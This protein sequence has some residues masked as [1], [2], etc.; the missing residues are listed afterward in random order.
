MTA[1]AAAVP[2]DPEA[3]RAFERAGWERAAAGYQS[4][5]ATVTR[6][7]IDPLLEDARIG[8]GMNVLDIAC[9]TGLVAARVAEYGAHVVGL[10]FSKAMLALARARHPAIAFDEGDAEA[11]PYADDTFDAVVSNFGIHHV[12][13][14][15]LALREACRVLRG[16]GRVAFTVWA[17]PAETIAWKLLFD[18]LARHGD[19]AAANA[20]V[21]GG[22]LGSPG[23][24]IDALRQAGF[25]A[26]QPRL[27]RRTWHHAGAADLVAALRA[28]TARMA[29]MIS[30]QD[31]ASMPA[32]VSDVERNAEPYRCAGGIAVPVAAFV[33]V[34]VKS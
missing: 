26:M 7:F 23:H 15:S 33:A 4:S 6:L 31:A 13:R 24:C 30:A 17:A 28:G 29:A 5:F 9:G 1:Q 18:A 10:D 16:G 32:I 14:P 2:F 20:P 19:P 22:G 27:L 8:P 21:P 25:A 12:P 34:G 11:L 3:V